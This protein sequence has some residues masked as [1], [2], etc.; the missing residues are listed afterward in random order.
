MG[1]PRLSAKVAAGFARRDPTTSIISLRFSY[2]IEPDD[3]AEELRRAGVDLAQN[4]FNLWAYVDARDVAT[5][6]RLAVERAPVGHHPLY[7]AAPDTLLSTPTLDAAMQVFPDIAKIA[8][9]FEGRMSPL[10]VS[11]AAELIG[12]HAA[13]DWG[14]PTPP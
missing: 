4:S 5:A 8:P 11:R 6:C 14:A 13:Y 3:F 9:S 2:I 1:S 7:I 12:F 10:N